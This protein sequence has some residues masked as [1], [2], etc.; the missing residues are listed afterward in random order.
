MRARF[1]LI[2]VM[3]TAFMLPTVSALEAD[4]RVSIS[5]CAAVTD[6]LQRLVC[7]DAIAKNAGVPSAA[8]GA[9]PL[10]LAG[11]TSTPKSSPTPE[12]TRSP[13]ARQ[14]CAATTKKGA[15]CS[16]PAQLG[17]SYCWQHQR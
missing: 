3:V 14:Q 15:R 8:T 6:S 12:T 10:P 5:K 2:I 1:P 11:L 16:R 13:T 9:G 7:Y 4:L 17:S